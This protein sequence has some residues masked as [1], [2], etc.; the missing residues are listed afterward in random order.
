MDRKDVKQRIQTYSKSDLHEWRK[1]AVKCL[2]YFLT[3]RDEF[4]IEECKF[5]I[6]EIDKRLNELK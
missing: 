2:N 4:E 5:V 1:H 3:Y 6:T